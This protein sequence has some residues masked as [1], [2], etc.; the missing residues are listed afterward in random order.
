MI[1]A[2]TDK[3]NVHLTIKM[4]QSPH[5]D[6]GRRPVEV[7]PIRSDPSINPL[8]QLESAL[9]VELARRAAEVLSLKVALILVKNSIPDNGSSEQ[10]LHRFL[11]IASPRL[12]RVEKDSRGQWQIASVRCDESRVTILLQ[13]AKNCSDTTIL[14]PAIGLAL[15]EVKASIAA[16]PIQQET[17]GKKPNLDFLQSSK[18]RVEGSTVE[19][20]VR[21]RAL[22]KEEVEQQYKSEEKGNESKEKEKWCVKISDVL[23]TYASSTVRR[24]AKFHPTQ[25]CCMTLMDAV[26]RVQ[27]QVSLTKRQIVDYMLQIAVILPEW[28]VMDVKSSEKASKTTSVWLTPSLYP[29][30]RYKLTNDAAPAKPLFTNAS[31]LLTTPKSV[32]QTVA[33]DKASPSEPLEKKPVEKIVPSTS[34]RASPEPTDP[35]PR[36]KQRTELRINSNLIWTDADYDGGEAIPLTFFDSPRGLKRLFDQMN[37]GRRI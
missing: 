28:I 37:A 5:G 11:G 15:N 19:E 14:D 29:S 4:Q 1:F 36:K 34:K 31:T 27:G 20:R 16:L 18:T 10:L 33:S 9:Q 23:Q 3:V 22:L 7:S 30:I 8:V 21:A 25:K 17:K 32:L 2:V 12:Y 26:V 24:Q 13:L 35:V 6:S